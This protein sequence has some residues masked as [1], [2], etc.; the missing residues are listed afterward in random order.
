LYRTVLIAILTIFVWATGALAKQPLKISVGLDKPPYVIQKT[1]H[2]FELEIVS[3]ALE[4]AG[5]KAIPRYMPLKRIPH[6]LNGGGLDGGMHM[7]AH[8]AIDGFFS[9]DVISYRNY[10]VTL[11]NSNISL[12]ELDDLAKYSVVSFQNAK[13]LLG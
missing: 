3:R 5:Y 2:G 9:N 4:I 13:K 1:N 7:R 8:M 12:K 11:K 10:A 6:E